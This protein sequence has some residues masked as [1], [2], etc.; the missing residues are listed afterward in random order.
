MQIDGYT[1]KTSATIVTVSTRSVVTGRGRCQNARCTPRARPAPTS[2]DS[3]VMACPDR[4]QALLQ[5]VARHEP[6][7][8]DPEDGH[9]ERHDDADRRAVAEPE[10][11]ERLDVDL[12]G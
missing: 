10:V 8:D 12:G 7:I 9:H 4:S 1:M 6:V 5:F 11:D 3:A 2:S